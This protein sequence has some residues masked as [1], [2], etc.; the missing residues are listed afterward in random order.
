MKAAIFVVGALYPGHRPAVSGH[1]QTSLKTAEILAKRGHEVTFITTS[2]WQ[3][4]RVPLPDSISRRVKVITLDVQTYGVVGELPRVSTAWVFFSELRR[5]LQA[6]DFSLVHFFGGNL[7]AYLLA[8]LKA[9]RLKAYSLMTMVQYSQPRHPL[10]AALERI[11]LK[12]IDSILALS[13][14]TRDGLTERGTGHVYV[15]RPG[16]LPQP[17]LRRNKPVMIRPDATDLVLFWRNASLVNGVDICMDAFE[18][19]SREFPSA[20]FVFAV[21]A[22][23]G[24]DL[25]LEELA[26]QHE[27]IHVLFAPYG[28]DMTIFDLIHSASCVVLPFRSLTCDP[29]L[30][31]LETILAGTFLVTTPVGSNR[32]LL[33]GIEGPCLVEPGNVEQTSSAIRYALKNKEEVKEVAR[34]ARSRALRDWNWNAYENALLETYAAGLGKRGGSYEEL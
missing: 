19:L 2:S 8:A 26:S 32:E 24:F 14:W 25:E 34:K 4:G 23:R 20:D 16:V 17:R 13:N 3:A 30:A 5:L 28:D 12:R 21:R 1:V 6:D 15:T 18:Q 11:L 31:V 10:Y 27:N 29:Q 7:T 22:G 33:E 9:T